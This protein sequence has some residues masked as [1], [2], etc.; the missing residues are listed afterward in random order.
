MKKASTLFTKALKALYA[1]SRLVAKPK[2]PYAIAEYLI[3]PVTV[4]LAENSQESTVTK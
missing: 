2:K 3:L 4:V 1:F